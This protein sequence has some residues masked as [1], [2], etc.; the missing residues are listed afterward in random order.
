MALITEHMNSIGVNNSIIND[1]K[2]HYFQ[3]VEYIERK[4]ED[5]VLGSK[6]LPV[7]ISNLR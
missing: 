4:K 3:I 2:Q 5:P 7:V 1:A 6:F